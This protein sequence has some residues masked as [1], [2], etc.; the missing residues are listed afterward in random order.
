MSITRS[1][2]RGGSPQDSRDPVPRGTTVRPSPAAACMVAAASAVLAG[3]AT[4]DGST[5]AIAS[6]GPARRRSAHA[7][8]SAACAAPGA[9][10]GR[11]AA[12][13]WPVWPPWPV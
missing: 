9:R 6:C 2:L 3:A 5:P 7:A 12:L 1:Q 8:A 4:Q 10:P 13:P 11:P